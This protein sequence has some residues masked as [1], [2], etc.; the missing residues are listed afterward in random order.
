MNNSEQLNGTA[1]SKSEP[2]NFTP[3]LY[4]KALTLKENKDVEI[5]KN[6]ILSGNIVIIKIT[7]YASSDVEGVKEIVE[8]LCRFSAKYGGDVARLG[9]ERIVMTPPTVK[10]WRRKKI[11]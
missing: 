9:D 2:D 7:P 8:E 10:I 1:S 4:V 3:P 6:E 5:I 11:E